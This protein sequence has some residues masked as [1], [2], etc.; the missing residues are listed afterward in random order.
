MYHDPDDLG[1]FGPPSTGLARLAIVLIQLEGK[2]CRLQR[3]LPKVIYEG[4]RPGPTGMAP[5]AVGPYTFQAG[6]SAA[7]AQRLVSPMVNAHLF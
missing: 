1:D 3:L 7:E 4:A 2:R 6:D 5:A